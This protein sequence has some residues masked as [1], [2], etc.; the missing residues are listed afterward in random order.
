MTAG[1]LLVARRHHG[2]DEVGR[3]VLLGLSHRTAGIE[4]RE[5]ASLSRPAARSVLSALRAHPGVRES[6]VLSTC[7]RIELLAVVGDSARGEVALGQALVDHT[8]IDSRE[9]RRATYTHR[10]ERAV[11]HLFRVAAALD[12]MVVGESEIQGQVRAALELARDE[13]SLGALLEPALRAALAAG[14]R[15]RSETRL[16]EGAVSVSSVA[17]QLA[18][19]ALG[20][21]HRRRVLLIGAGR[22]AEATARALVG[23]GLREVV[24][25]NHTPATAS[26]I[27][28]RFGGRAVGLDA[29]V[30]E[31]GTADVVISSTDAPH[32]VLDVETVAAAVTP[33]RR[34][35]L[36]L[37]DVAVPR[38]IDPRVQGLRGIRLH[39][40]DDLKRAAEANL[41]GRRRE[42][43][44]AEVI[45][46]EEA[47]R[48]WARVRSGGASI[49]RQPRPPSSDAPCSSSDTCQV[50]GT[51]AGR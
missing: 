37:I 29:L 24:V 17:V 42:A 26:R 12:S 9:L 32:P 25:A 30:G 38:D 50:G 46:A 15:V 34:Q 6:A 35:P 36:V 51:A 5:R 4:Q 44:R 13:G 39:N 11:R 14:R 19:T 48:F 20:D 3:L 8:R 18:R 23:H 22:A 33:E 27:A 2:G 43:E 7:N 41:N 47:R 45:V 16:A 21:L 1:D 31:L 40:I 28:T 49:G 10:D